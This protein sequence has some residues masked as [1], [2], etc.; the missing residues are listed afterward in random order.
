[1]PP[2]AS[3]TLPGET[4]DALPLEAWTERQ[5]RI[6]AAKLAR[7][8]SATWLICNR[9]SFGQTIRPAKGSVLA[10]PEIDLAGGP[11]YFFHWLRD[12]AA[13]MDAAL[14]LVEGPEGRA[15]I[16]RFEDWV[17]FTLGLGRLDGNAFLQR[18]DFRR[19]VQD[20]AQQFVR[21]DEEIAA[22]AGDRAFDDVRYGAD[23][24]LDFIKWSRPQHDGA[25][26]GVLAALRFW[27]R[28]ISTGDAARQSLADLIGQSLDYTAARA[29]A[30]SY[31]IWEED[32]GHHYYTRL[33]Q[34]TALEEGTAWIEAGGDR[35]GDRDRAA[36][37]RDAAAILA[38]ALDGF[39]SEERGIYRSRNEPSGPSPK[40]LDMAV[41]LAVLHAG[42]GA[43]A[44]SVADPRI[45]STM[46]RLEEMFAADYA[47][48][49]G[50]ARPFAFGRYRGDRYFSGGAWYL[51][52]FAAAE[53]HYRAAASASPADADA[54]LARGDAILAAV[55][56]HIPASGELSEQFDQTTGAQTSAKNLTWSYAAFLTAWNA[57]KTAAR[58][59]PTGAAKPA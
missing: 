29:E 57:R 19:P 14:V 30:P 33:V 49:R 44:H 32:L 25:A 3:E 7:A 31:D 54:L 38:Q 48:N 22:V 53:F 15:W 8:I 9:R 24:E 11:D 10:S 21:P 5:A 37:Y 56:G 47:L 55:R 46:A 59:A 4:V 42:R 36:R 20:W 34:W 1:M 35:H 41:I 50:H 18:G 40:A 17:G 6:S 39:W 27:R 45:A 16:E 2:S 13:V 23:G 52:S 51:A 58:R 12:G 28:N 26:L 43:G